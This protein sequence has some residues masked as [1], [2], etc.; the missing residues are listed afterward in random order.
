MNNFGG[1]V[2][3]RPS[4]KSLRQTGD[5]NPLGEVGRTELS[6]IGVK[7]LIRHL[8]N[9]CSEKASAGRP[10]FYLNTEHK[11]EDETMD[12]RFDKLK[13]ARTCL[14]DL[15]ER[16]FSTITKKVIEVDGKKYKLKEL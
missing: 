1:R 13:D 16:R 8:G 15:V 5:E 14:R 4:G 3:I 10:S 6:S 7:A 2:E 9:P 11:N 12:W